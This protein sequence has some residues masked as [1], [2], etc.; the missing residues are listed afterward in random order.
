MLDND[1]RLT[2]GERLT[3]ARDDSGLS[4]RLA[5]RKL[6]LLLGDGAPSHETLRRYHNGEVGPT[7]VKIDT[8]IGL[9]AVYDVSLDELSPTV[10]DRSRRLVELAEQVGL[11][12]KK[13]PQTRRSAPGSNSRWSSTTRPV[14][15]RP[16]RAVA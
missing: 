4:L 11:K 2:L 6:W 7:D 13:K 16:R 3:K 10:G 5:E 15:T 14:P 8:M 12:A 1:N 9:A